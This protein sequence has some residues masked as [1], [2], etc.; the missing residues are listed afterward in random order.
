[1]DT[2]NKLPFRNINKY[3]RK[4]CT[5]ML[6]WKAGYKRTETNL[7]IIMQIMTPLF[8]LQEA[9][10]KKRYQTQE[11]KFFPD[12][13]LAIIR[14]YFVVDA[15]AIML[16]DFKKVCYGMLRQ[17][18]PLNFGILCSGL[19]IQ[20]PRLIA[21]YQH[22]MNEFD[23]TVFEYS[24]YEDDV[25]D[26]DD[27]YNDPFHSMVLLPQHV[28][29]HSDMDTTNTYEPTG[30]KTHTIVHSD[31]KHMRNKGLILKSHRTDNGYGKGMRKHKT[32]RTHRRNECAY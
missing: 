25:F 5:I 16:D 3:F 30:I 1:M 2:Q 27:I 15:Y 8:E 28:Y 13:G 29:E 4:A 19:Q 18:H 7:E 10:Y 21:N 11:S 26:E 31:T 32:S 6:L 22:K 9:H 24:I 17:M 23:K 20:V 12:C 14:G